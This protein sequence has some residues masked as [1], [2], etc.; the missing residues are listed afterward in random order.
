MCTAVQG[1]VF[2]FTVCFLSFYFNLYY[3]QRAFYPKELE[4][5]ENDFGTLVR[6]YLCFQLPNSSPVPISEE[7]K[8]KSL[9]DS[10]LPVHLLKPGTR[11]FT[12]SCREV[13]DS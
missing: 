1:N 12:M 11:I 3:L 13:Y 9:L 6:K 2:S 10:V 5:G 4:I 8:H 7:S